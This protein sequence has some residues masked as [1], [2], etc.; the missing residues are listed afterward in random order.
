[1]AWPPPGYVPQPLVY[2]RWS[3]SYPYPKT[4]F[5]PT[6][7]GGWNISK[8]VSFADATVQLFLDGKPIDATI[9]HATPADG[10]AALPTLVWYSSV[11]WAELDDSQDHKVQVQ[12]RN[13]FVDGQS[14]EFRYTV[15]IFDPES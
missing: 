3:F 7:E 13:V 12:I 9:E 14:Q 6:P 11:D 8:N 1:V 15:T 4:S 10:Y 2:P 5:E